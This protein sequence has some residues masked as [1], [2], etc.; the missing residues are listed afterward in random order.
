MIRN[1]NLITSNFQEPIEIEFRKDV[2][3][4]GYFGSD[5]FGSLEQITKDAQAKDD[6]ITYEDVREWKSKQSFGQKNETSWK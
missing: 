1:R 6:T 5:G 3:P 4:G 2:S